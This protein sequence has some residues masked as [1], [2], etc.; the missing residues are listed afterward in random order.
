[1]DLTNW[2]QKKLTALMGEVT[3]SGLVSFAAIEASVEW[4]LAGSI[5]VAQLRNAIN[6]Q[7]KFWL[8]G[9]ENIATDMAP[10]N[11]AGSPR[12]AARYFS[13]RWQIG[14]DQL[15]GLDRHFKAGELRTMA[16]RLY[17]LVETEGIW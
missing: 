2:R 11:V 5:L 12:E 15:M 13:L 14:V 4:S 10:F 6:H 17:T 8:I 16:E 9:G 3:E 7:E 1:M